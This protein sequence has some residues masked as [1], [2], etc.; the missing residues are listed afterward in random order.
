MKLP[1]HMVS[2]PAGVAK[3]LCLAT[4]T[5]MPHL[6][7]IHHSICLVRQ[8]Q[9]TSFPTLA[10]VRLA[11]YPSLPSTESYGDAHASCHS[12]F[13]LS[14][15]ADSKG[16]LTDRIPLLAAELGQLLVSSPGGVH[17]QKNTLRQTRSLWVR[18]PGTEYW[19][20]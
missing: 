16:P 6:R 7:A 20:P 8:I 1:P 5:G 18:I 2:F 17:Q 19:R 9:M 11:S 10:D 13:D 15:P 14:C 12:P 4:A 3:D